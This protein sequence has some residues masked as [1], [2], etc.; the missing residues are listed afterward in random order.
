[1]TGIKQILT[2][3]N[4]WLARLGLCPNARDLGEIPWS[5]EMGKLCER[6]H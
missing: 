2:N 5:R 6:A 4:P 1:M 3:E